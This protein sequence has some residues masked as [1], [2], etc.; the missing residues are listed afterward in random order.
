MTEERREH[1]RHTLS[2]EC[3]L[4]WSGASARI[5]DLSLGGC[6]VDCQAVPSVGETTEVTVAFDG[7]P[8]RLRGRVVNVQRGF[9]FGLEF[10]DLDEPTLKRLRNFLSVTG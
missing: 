8:T 4:S 7:M 10:T 2:L 3:T 5:S 6:F 9:G 1:S